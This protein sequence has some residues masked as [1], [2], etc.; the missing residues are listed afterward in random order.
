[1]LVAVSL[2]LAVLSIDFTGIVVALPTIGADLGVPASNLGWVINAFA[3][4]F[5]GLLLVAGKVSD[6]VGHRAVLL[7]GL[8]VF[9]VGSVVCGLSQTFEVLVSGRVV[10]G[11]GTAGF[12]TASLAIVSGAF[13]DPDRPRAIGLWGAVGGAASAVGPLVA[14]AVTE[15]A[16]WRWFFTL[17]LPLLAVSIV[18]SRRTIA[19]PTGRR[20]RNRP[21]FDVAGAALGTLGIVLLV[22]ALQQMADHTLTSVEVW[23]PAVGGAVCL[24]SFLWVE[25]RAVDPIVAPALLHRPAYLRPTVAALV[26]NVGFGALQLLVTFE[27]QGEAGWSA[28]ATGAAFLVYSAPFALVGGAM[29]RLTDRWSVATLLTAGLVTVAASFG[30]LT[31]IGPLPSVAVAGA[32]LV[33]GVGQG[34]VYSAS[35]TAAMGAVDEA[36]TGEASGLLGVAR[37]VGLATGIAVASIAV[38]RPDDVAVGITLAAAALALLTAAV[39]AWSRRASAPREVA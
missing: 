33:G 16:S 22:V 26:A 21:R 34:L 37:N 4:G 7:A 35:S 39:A 11:M 24:G 27:L 28:L 38:A 31:L 5:A 1:V 20:A 3:L 30:V 10:Q 6:L 36:G 14:G 29:G 17:N 18:L 12:M 32:L 19:P 23:G 8:V 15:W 9:A 2:P 13:A 25:R